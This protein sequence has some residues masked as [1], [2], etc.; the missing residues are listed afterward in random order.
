MQG[1]Q[2]VS[3]TIAFLIFLP[4]LLYFNKLLPTLIPF[5]FSNATYG[6]GWEKGCMKK[7]YIDTFQPSPLTFTP[8]T[9][10]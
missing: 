2:T 5:L 10:V 4:F 9:Y 8:P 6:R 7:A 3:W 1:S